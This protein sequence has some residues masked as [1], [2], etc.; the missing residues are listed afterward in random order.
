MSGKPFFRSRNR[1]H[2]PVF[3]PPWVELLEARLSP[4]EGVLGGLLAAAWLQPPTSIADSD[5]AAYA[6][7][8]LVETWSDPSV[9]A[10]FS[11]VEEALSDRRL[12]ADQDTVTMDA[13]ASA[14]L[15]GVDTGLFEPVGVLDG[16]GFGAW[17]PAGSLGG[18]GA[19]GALGARTEGQGF[20]A[21]GSGTAAPEGATEAVS[22]G[23][24]A[25][26]P[27][28]IA[29]SSSPG[30]AADLSPGS[31]PP[32]DLGRHFPTAPIGGSDLGSSVLPPISGTAP[33]TA[34]L[35]GFG[36]V[37]HQRLQ[38]GTSAVTST[39]SFAPTTLASRTFG[40]PGQHGRRPAQFLAAADNTSKPLLLHVHQPG[41]GN[42]TGITGAVSPPA[43][44]PR[45][46]DR[47]PA[48]LTQRINT[49][50][51]QQAGT[52]PAAHSVR[53]WQAQRI[54]VEPT[55]PSGDTTDP[56]PLDN[57][58]Q[59]DQ[60]QGSFN[61]TLNLH[62]SDAQGLYALRSTGT[63]RSVGGDSNIG[64]IKI[65]TRIHRGGGEVSDADPPATE[66]LSFDPSGTGVLI[67]FDVDGYV[68]ARFGIA[69]ATVTTYSLDAGGSD[70]FSDNDTQTTVTHPGSGETETDALAFVDNGR[71]SYR[72]TVTGS[73]GS[74]TY[75]LNLHANSM[76][77]FTEDDNDQVTLTGEGESDLYHE[78]ESGSETL[79][80]R[81]AGTIGANG[82]PQMNSFRLTDTA[83]DT[84][85]DTEA[86]QVRKTPAQQSGTE[87]FLESETSSGTEAVTITGSASSWSL[88]VDDNNAARI[89]EQEQGN[90]HLSGMLPN[91][92]TFQ[93]D[94]QWTDSA[95]GQATETLHARASGDTSDN[96]SI[97]DLTYREVGSDTFDARDTDTE[98]DALG[99]DSSAET[100]SATG[101]G[102][103]DFTLTVTSPDGQ[104]VTVT[105]TETVGDNFTDGDRGS[106][107]WNDPY[108]GGGTDSGSDGYNQSDNGNETTQLTSRWTVTA[109]GQFQLNTFDADV[110]GGGATQGND[111]G[112]GTIHV[113]GE[114]DRL[115]YAD[116][117]TARDNYHIH[118]V[119]SGGPTTTVDIDETTTDTEGDT[120]TQ[121]DDWSNASDTGHDVDTQTDGDTATVTGQRSGTI[122]DQGQYTQ[123]RVTAH[124]D[125]TDRFGNRDD[126]DDDVRNADGDDDVTQDS[127][128]SGTDES[129][130]DWTETPAGVTLSDDES[131]RE[132]F[133]IGATFTETGTVQGGGT[134]HISGPITANIHQRGHTQGGVF[135]FDPANGDDS[136][137]L[138]GDFDR[139][140]TVTSPGTQYTQEIDLNTHSTWGPIDVR[141]NRAV[142]T[143]EVMDG[144]LHLAESDSE[145]NGQWSV[146]M[147]DYHDTPAVTITTTITYGTLENLGGYTPPDIMA[148][149]TETVVD[150]QSEDETVQGSGTRD[151]VTLMTNKVHTDSGHIEGSFTE[152]WVTTQPAMFHGSLDFRS[153]STTRHAIDGDEANTHDDS[154]QDT[155]TVHTDLHSVEDTLDQ[156]TESPITLEHYND[157][158]DGADD[159]TAADTLTNGNA[160]K[161]DYHGTGQTTTVFTITQTHPRGTLVT[162]T[163]WNTTLT[164]SL[165]G[166]EPDDKTD[167]TAHGRRDGVDP[168]TGQEVHQDFDPGDHHYEGPGPR[169]WF[170]AVATFAAGVGDKISGG[171][172]RRIRQSLGYDDVVHYNSRAYSSGEVVGEVINVGVENLTPCRFVGVLRT[173]VRVLHG[174]QASAHLLDASES[175]QKYDVI[176]GLDALAAAR[177][178]FGAMRTSCFPAGTPLRTPAGSKPIEQFQVGDV[179]LSRDEH[180]AAGPVETKTVQ[181]VFIRQSLVLAL[182]IDGRIIRT[183]AEHPFW[184]EG[185]GWHCAKELAP[186]DR[187]VTLRGEGETVLV[188]E[189][190]DTGESETVYNLQV[191]DH[192]TY[193]V[194]T[195]EWGWA[196]WAH[197][198]AYVDLAA[199]YAP[200]KKGL[201]G[202]R[203]PYAAKAKTV[204]AR[205]SKLAGDHTLPQ[206]EVGNVLKKFFKDNRGQ[207]TSR[208]EQ[209][210][211]AAVN[212]ILHGRG[213]M[214][215]MPRGLNSAK[216]NRNAAE[217]ARTPLGKDVNPSYVGYIQ[218]IQRNTANKINEVLNKGQSQ[219]Q[220]WFARFFAGS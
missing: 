154:L 28:G 67:G 161:T 218:R 205:R 142:T 20:G 207:V 84:D 212:E 10:I 99:P 136:V 109:D 159:Y 25:G 2:R 34:S 191:A 152:Y 147:V 116:N 81:E 171:L 76:F 89:G 70:R 18:W 179:L 94:D 48:A 123:T 216:R 37:S 52:N 137:N 33:S 120:E 93:D 23:V 167:Q 3:S 211:R 107:T 209:E 118:F 63:G 75:E 32:A 199:R 53:G 51:P 156:D 54:S 166:G 202:Y 192:H 168:N 11:P 73:G 149:G 12:P 40:E 41:H 19:A 164:H 56:G 131:I 78:G 177:S 133:G 47:N 113:T 13:F 15:R 128:V 220:D 29:S 30:S 127:G 178:S 79:T 201:I 189:V 58:T 214:R 68:A 103:N 65:T 96:V 163:T 38:G 169:D 184:V 88:T 77:R 208:Q 158:T 71:D 188:E 87:N 198:A 200:K 160:V 62:G 82:I 31:P 5:R 72:L 1:R 141:A 165:V 9:M 195:P 122:D 144:G 210:I 197:N 111:S 206:K 85:T 24:V 190:R 146:G 59:N 186:G 101:Q 217:F 106:D 155:V 100:E 180:N 129:H 157:T 126:L 193:F 132:N 134:G 64:R 151:H 8:D 139:T 176:G 187:L 124:F 86:S 181:D 98:V 49:F 14:G 39:S 45:K 215:V 138:T 80:D 172:T 66:T 60:T 162:T 57:Q 121:T 91:N 175:F 36:F 148:S 115:D 104:A 203:D 117:S 173:G 16:D 17:L 219:A 183:T 119:N 204:Y 185:K 108:Q 174:V 35:A 105:E 194:G 114:T 22:A 102:R 46:S 21:Q 69:L 6:R 196:V 44:M 61:F 27:A 140:T 145:A 153:T 42:G 55:A 92:G 83:S 50:R 95:N 110:R 130:I 74:R 143:T 4:G 170:D 135:G 112:N 182:Q 7:S 26:F 90:A 213:N 150:R 125:G 97:Q 43:L